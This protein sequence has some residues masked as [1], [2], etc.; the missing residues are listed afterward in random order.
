MK[1]GPSGKPWCK[2]IRCLIVSIPGVSDYGEYKL[3]RLLS[4]CL[5]CCAV[6]ALGFVR[7]FGARADDGCSIVV[8][9]LVVI[10]N[11]CWFGERLAVASDICGLRPNKAYQIVNRARFVVRDLEEER[12]DDLSESCEVGFGQLYEDRIE[13]VK[14]VGEFRHNLLGRHGAPKMVRPLY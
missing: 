1:I 5:V 13:V 3:S 14:G 11:Y 9:C 10:P 6:H 8:N 2:L 4:C 7:R 12:S